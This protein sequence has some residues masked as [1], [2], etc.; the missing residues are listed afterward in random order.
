MKTFLLLRI[1]LAL[2]IT[3]IIIMAG[4]TMI[5]Y[6]TFKTFWKLADQGDVRSAGLLPLMAKF[7]AFVRTGA[8]IILLTGGA[9]LIVGKG[10]WW[11]QPWFKIKMGLVLLLVLHGSLI[12]NKQ[13]QKLRETAWAHAADF[14]QRTMDLREYLNRFYLIQLTLFFLLILISVIKVNRISN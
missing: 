3:G 4:A 7:G 13:G 1:L 11:Q 9:M 5:D 14:M 8:A 6:L 10:V 2:H 12:G